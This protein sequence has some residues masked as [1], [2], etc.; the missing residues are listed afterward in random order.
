MKRFTQLLTALVICSLVITISCKKKSSS[1]DDPDVRDAFGTALNGTTWVATTVTLD[2]SNRTDWGDF[3]LGFTGYNTESDEGTYSTN[4]VPSD[5][6]AAIVWGAGTQ[7]WQ[8]G[9]TDDS[10]DISKIVRLSDG[11]E[12]NITP[13]NSDDPTQL[14]ITFSTETSSGRLAGFEGVWSFTLERQ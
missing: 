8:F 13:D 7:S 14:I 12:L 5:D 2:N 4:G 11:R 9:G 10:P 1:E 3:V 6:D